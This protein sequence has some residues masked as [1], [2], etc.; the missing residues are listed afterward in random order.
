MQ[1]LMRMTPVERREFLKTH[2]EIRERMM[3]FR[4]Q[5]HE[6]WQSMTPEQKQQFLQNHPRIAEF[7]KNHQK[8]AN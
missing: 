3:E 5:M 4:K 7:L 6:K 1:K 2:P 8:A